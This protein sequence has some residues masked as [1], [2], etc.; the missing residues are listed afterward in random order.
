MLGVVAQELE[1][2][3]M[4]GLVKTANDE[5]TGEEIKSVKYSVLYMKAIKALQE[6][7]AKVEA[8]ET[9]NA[10]IKARLDA[11]EGS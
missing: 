10:A 9:E 6:T 1:A 5:D 8:L 7:I 4:T 2:S 11:I 3:G